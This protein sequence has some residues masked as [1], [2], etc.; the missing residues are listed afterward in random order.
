MILFRV[1]AIPRPQRPTEYHAFPAGKKHL[2][3]AHRETIVARR[4]AALVGKSDVANTWAHIG[5]LPGPPTVL[6]IRAGRELP[7]DSSRVF[8][9]PLRLAVALQEIARRKS[10]LAYHLRADFVVE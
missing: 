8:D 1:G 5:K 9:A 6:V 2:R 4:I 3:G 10:R 7:R